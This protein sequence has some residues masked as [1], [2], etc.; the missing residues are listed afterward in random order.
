M[1]MW[2]KRGSNLRPESPTASLLPLS[3]RPC[4]MD[5]LSLLADHLT[6][7]S[8]FLPEEKVQ[9]S[10]RFPN[11]HRPDRRRL[12][13]LLGILLALN[14]IVRVKTSNSVK[15]IRH[16]LS[17]ILTRVPR[18]TVVQWFE[19]INSIACTLYRSIAEINLMH[20]SIDMDSDL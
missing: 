11:H 10:H 12:F 14:A 18:S 7:V 5:F 16:V 2:C 20:C 8:P 4:C 3:Q 9:D 13:W 1:E 6:V 19:L 17:Y 15:E